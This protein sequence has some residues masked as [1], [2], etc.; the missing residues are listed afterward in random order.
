MSTTQWSTSET[1]GADAMDGADLDPRNEDEWAALQRAGQRLLEHTLERYRQLRDRPVYEPVPARV[2]QSL[3]AAPPREGLGV[4]AALERALELIAPFGPGNVDPRFWGWVLGAGNLPGML[5]Q[6]L[7][8]SMNANA[9]AGDQAPVWLELEVLRWFRDWFEF[10]QTSSGL[11]LEGTSSA[12]VLALAIARHRATNGDVA[13]RGL[14][15][16]AV[17]RLYCSSETHVSIAKAAQL[18]GLGRDGVC[19]VPARPDGSGDVAR[20]ERAIEDDRRAGL[21]PFCVVGSA[22]TVGVGALDPLLELQA[23]SA[24]H[25]LWFHVDGAIGALG[26]LSPALRPRLAGLGLA[27]SLAFDLHKWAQVPYDCGCLLVRD[28]ALHRAAFALDTDYLGTTDGGLTRH[29]S[30]AFQDLGPGLSRPDRATKVWMTFMAIGSERI[31]RVFEANVAQARWLGQRIQREPELELANTVALNIVC[32][33]Y[34]AGCVDDGALGS[35]QEHIASELRASGLCVL[36]PFRVGGVPCLRVAL[37][38]HRTQQG[39][40]ESLVQRVLEL[41]RLELGR[42]GSTRSSSAAR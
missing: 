18:L 2:K 4:E 29:G 34:R 31:V 17:L 13:R 5:G 7:A 22:G 26:Y 15:G 11:L 27:D 16:R 8:S 23:L 41:G 30:P 6:W 35:L 9:W 28:G 1:A 42:R 14:A 20:L 36:S 40:L 10:P 24:R 21:Q 39:D 32:F 25:G 12:N 3:T 33:R 38:N 37:S 19:W